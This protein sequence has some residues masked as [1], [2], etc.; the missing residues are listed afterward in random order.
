MN[1]HYYHKKFLVS[2]RVGNSHWG[3]LSKHVFIPCFGKNYDQEIDCRY[4]MRN[5]KRIYNIVNKDGLKLEPNFHESMYENNTVEEIAD[6]WFV[7][8][9]LPFMRWV[10][11]N[12]F[13]LRNYI[14]ILKREWEKES[15]SLN[16]FKECIEK[17]KQK[18]DT[19]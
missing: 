12:K 6:Q 11:R 10:I 14:R 7:N 16:T 18:E 13:V 8:Y 1:A 3:I 15:S 17:I 9:T 2:K 5:I 4:V 19:L